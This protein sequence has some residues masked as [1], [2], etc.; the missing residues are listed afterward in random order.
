MKRLIRVLAV[1]LFVLLSSVFMMRELDAR[2]GRGGGRGGGGG[3]R[4]GGGG[5]RGGGRGG[6]GG[7]R[8]KG[9][10][11]SGGEQSRKDVTKDLE[12][13]RAAEERE[14]RIA[15]ARR[16]GATSAFD[17]LQKK[18]LDAEREKVAAERRRD[19]RGRANPG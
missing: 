3:G 17:D 15:D 9:G 14:S 10:G 13:R 19:W 1:S 7:G 18:I 6:R 2:G 4:G 5:G 16:I 11:G 8:G 12:E